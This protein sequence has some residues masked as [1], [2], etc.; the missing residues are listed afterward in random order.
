[1]PLPTDEKNRSLATGSGF[2]WG[3]SGSIGSPHRYIS[4]VTYCLPTATDYTAHLNVT[5]LKQCANYL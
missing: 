2:L 1:V 5:S 4:Y 3:A